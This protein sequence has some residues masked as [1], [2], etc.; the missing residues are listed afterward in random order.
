MIPFSSKILFILIFTI[1][2]IV[3]KISNE[4]NRD[5]SLYLNWIYGEH[6][7]DKKG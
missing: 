1:I 3:N 2:V 5:H 6:E 7:I 4:S